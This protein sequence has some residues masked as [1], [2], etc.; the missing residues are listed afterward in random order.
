MWSFTFIAFND[1]YCTFTRDEKKGRGNGKCWTSKDR[2]P[3]TN[4]TTL[5]SI[6]PHCPRTLWRCWPVHSDKK[7]W[8]SWRH[9]YCSRAPDAVAPVRPHVVACAHAV[10][11]A[12]TRNRIHP[13]ALGAAAWGSYGAPGRRPHSDRA[14]EH[15]P[16]HCAARPHE[17]NPA[18]STWTRDSQ[19]GSRARG[20]VLLPDWGTWWCR[21][22]DNRPGQL[23]I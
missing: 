23:T 10:R 3:N 19:C 7:I 8:L 21:W 2:T 5:S 14:A 12:Y 1:I 15:Q 17:D 9:C 16:P 4:Y 11:P 6:P 20:C 22:R 18:W 13:P